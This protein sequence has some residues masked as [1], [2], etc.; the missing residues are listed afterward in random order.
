MG[1]AALARLGLLVALCFAAAESLWRRGTD[2]TDPTD[3]RPLLMGGH[4]VPDVYL[5]GLSAGGPV[6]QGHPGVGGLR[7]PGYGRFVMHS[8]SPMQKPYTPEQMG[9]L[10]GLS[11]S[12][13]LPNAPNNRGEFRAIVQGENSHP[14]DRNFFTSPRD[15]NGRRIDHIILEHWSG[16]GVTLHPA[17]PRGMLYSTGP[18]MAASHAACVMK[19]LNDTKHWNVG[20]RR[21]CIALCRPYAQAGYVPYHP[22]SE[23]YTPYQP[24]AP[25]NP[26]EP[27]FQPRSTSSSNMPVPVASSSMGW[28]AHRSRTFGD[29]TGGRGDI[30]PDWAMRTGGSWGQPFGRRSWESAMRYFFPEYPPMTPEQGEFEGRVARGE[31]MR[32]SQIP[33]HA[34]VR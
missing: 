26:W 12:M 10:Y 15:P 1:F 11:G 20:D 33:F 3:N 14:K 17:S 31:A 24:Y 27:Y 2:D 34:G 23:S 4:R 18:I 16:N 9:Q 25:H 28:F 13:D 7:V 19:C 22:M 30:G 6:P 29:P 21:A 8:F 5:P 32:A